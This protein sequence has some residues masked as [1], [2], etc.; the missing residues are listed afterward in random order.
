MRS[1]N[2]ELNALRA[3]LISLWNPSAAVSTHPDQYVITIRIRLATDHRLVGQP[4][5]LTNSGGPLFEAVRD[6]AVRA[7]LQAQPYDILSQSTYDKWK[8]IDINFDPREVVASEPSEIPSSAP[9]QVPP[10]DRVFYTEYLPNWGFDCEKPLL[11]T[12]NPWS[13]LE[14]CE[15]MYKANYFVEFTCEDEALFKQRT[16]P[17]LLVQSD[18]K[19]LSNVANRRRACIGLLAEKGKLSVWDKISRWWTRKEP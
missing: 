6:S 9:A 19:W 12:L 17:H 16:A 3:K 4:E 7:V 13:S 2:E 14:A 10:E 1:L 5:V 18:I 8:E 11:N 15:G